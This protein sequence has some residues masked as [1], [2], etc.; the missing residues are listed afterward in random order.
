MSAAQYNIVVEQGG[1]FSVVFTLTGITLDSDFSARSQ[2]RK[3]VDSEAV[4]AE[5]TCTIDTGGNT[6]TAKLENVKSSA[7]LA[8]DYVYDLEL[9]DAGQTP[10]EITKLVKGKVTILREVTR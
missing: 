8:G 3:T 9:V 1:D 6:V 4:A 5:F 10:S 2:I 7:M